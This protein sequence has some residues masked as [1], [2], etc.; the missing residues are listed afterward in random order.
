MTT[1]QLL[2]S[3]FVSFIPVFLLD[4]RKEMINSIEDAFCPIPE[5][6]NWAGRVQ[7]KFGSLY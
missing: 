2:G 6:I 1:V 3:D 4:G 5:G 7:C